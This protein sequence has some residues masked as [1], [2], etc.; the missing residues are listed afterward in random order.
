VTA[1][2]PVQDSSHGIRA[3]GFEDTA[4][5]QSLDLIRKGKPVFGPRPALCC[6]GV[7]AP[8]I[9]RW[10]F[11]VDR[12]TF[13]FLERLGPAILEVMDNRINFSQTTAVGK[14]F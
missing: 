10:T 12:W 6:I 11:D 9:R 5:W 13:V 7:F 2:G 1:Q 8:L 3:S 4:V 14:L